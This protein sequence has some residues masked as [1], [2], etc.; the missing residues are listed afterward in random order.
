MGTISYIIHTV[1]STDICRSLLASL[2]MLR[3]SQT[4]R[5]LLVCLVNMLT[6]Q[7]TVEGLSTILQTP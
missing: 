4:A 3:E 6:H 2:R 5:L 1:Y 7:K